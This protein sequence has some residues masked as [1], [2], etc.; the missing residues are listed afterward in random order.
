MSDLSKACEQMAKDCVWLRVRQ[1][2]RALTTIYDAYLRPTGLLSSQLPIL[3]AIA[4]LQEKEAGIGEVARQLLMDRT[5]LTRNLRPLEK[6]GFV[7]V[8]R[9][10]TDARSRILLLTPAGVRALEAAF[11]LWE[12]A[13]QAATAGVGAKSMN[14]LLLRLRSLAALDRVSESAE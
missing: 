1:A 9:S 10:P 8:A 13:Q 5:T 14:E 3:V 4:L 12:Q 11:P 2:S 6:G 7:R